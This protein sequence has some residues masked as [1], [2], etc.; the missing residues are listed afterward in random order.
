[1][2]IQVMMETLVTELNAASAA[3]Y[4]G[5]PEKMSDA[6]YDDKINFLASLESRYPEYKVE[7]TPTGRVGYGSTLSHLEKVEHPEKMLSLD[8]R[9]R[10]GEICDFFSGSFPVIGS[11]KFDG[12]TVV[13]TYQNGVLADCVTRGNGIVGDRII[14]A[15]R[16]FKNLPAVIPFKGKLILRA[17]AIIR[18][19]KFQRIREENPDKDFKNARNLTS[20]TVRSFDLNLIAEREVE[21]HVFEVI[22]A[23]PAVDDRVPDSVWERDSSARNWVETLGFTCIAYKVLETDAEV[24]S[25]RDYVESMRDTYVYGTDGIV[26]SMDSLEKREKAGKTAK[27]PLYALAYKF[28][29]KGLVSTVTSITWQ[30]GMFS[31]TPVVHIEPLEFD[32]VT[33]SRATAH[34]LCF[35]MGKDL[36]GNICRPPLVKGCQVRIERGGEV[37]PKIADVF[38]ENAVLEDMEEFC[39]PKACPEC[40][41]PTNSHGVELVCSNPRCAGKLKAK[42]RTIVSKNALDISGMG[43][44]AIDIFVE[45]GLICSESDL[46]HLEEKRD[47]LLSLEGFGEKKVNNLIYQIQQSKEAKLPNVISA[48]CI[49]GVGIEIARLIAK[50]MPHGLIDMLSLEKSRYMSMDGIG[51]VIAENICSFVMN[52]H[53]LQYIAELINEGYGATEESGEG[54]PSSD[55]LDGLTI[56][57]TGTLSVPR[58]EM[59]EFIRRNGGKATGSVSKKTSYVLVGESAGASKLAKA[60]EYSIPQVDETFIRSMVH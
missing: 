48:L 34:N 28:P 45:K 3:Y 37:I 23:E 8:K 51:D 15:A 7:G 25:Y 43:N 29:N 5:E 58:A 39:Y 21:A 56:C 60:E 49:K 1:M 57:I 27:Y 44:S 55:C 11:L 26:F 6:E 46:L 54:L 52:E 20:G 10:I 38:Y 2:D 9:Y 59:E 36:H 40:G 32:G 33:V 31:I 22:S 35:V 47:E 17:E 14:K 24:Q 12:L 30:A 13:L 18:Q 16:T 53:G 42:L 4:N 41:F 50:L 19:D